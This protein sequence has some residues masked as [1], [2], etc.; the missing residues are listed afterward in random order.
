MQYRAALLLTLVVAT[1]DD[2]AIVDQ[3]RADRHATCGM[4]LLGLLDGRL[5]ETFVILSLR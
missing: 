2:L 5:Q 1:P 3:Y 4:A